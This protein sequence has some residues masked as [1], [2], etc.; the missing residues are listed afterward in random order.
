[1]KEIQQLL[2]TFLLVTALLLMTVSATLADSLWSEQSNSLYGNQSSSL[3][4]AKSRTFQV[5]D[6]LTIDII[7]QAKASSQAT[8][9]NA[10]KGSVLAGPGSGLLNALPQMGAT[11]DASNRGDG[12]TT[13]GGSLSAKIT[14][15]VKEVNP[16][17]ILMVEGRQV[18]KVNGEEQ[19]LTVSGLARTE[20]ISPENVILSSYIASAVIDYEG[21]GTVG[22]TQKSGLITKFFHWLF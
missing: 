14:V 18:I 19:V 4:G 7:E 20:D 11:W 3:Y 21:K 13:R 2:A 15:Q 5:G 10:K 17:G 12:A 22:E 16:N 6:L 9:S 1:M 8:T